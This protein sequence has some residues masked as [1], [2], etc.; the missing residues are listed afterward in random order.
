M[1][2]TLKEEV[3]GIYQHGQQVEPRFAR[4]HYYRWKVEGSDK[5][6]KRIKCP[7]K[8]VLL[9]WKLGLFRKYETKKGREL[10][11]GGILVG[12]ATRKRG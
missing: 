7:V 2:Y 8:Q 11:E 9:F 6:L 10:V 1:G 3:D 12:G 5:D 4:H